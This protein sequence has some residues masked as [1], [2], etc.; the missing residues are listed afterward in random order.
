MWSLACMPSR[1]RRVKCREAQTW[2]KVWKLQWPTSSSSSRSQPRRASCT[3]LHESNQL[4]HAASKHLLY[5]SL[6]VTTSE[7]LTRDDR[8]TRH[9]ADKQPINQYKRLDNTYNIRCDK[10]D[11]TTLELAPDLGKRTS[12]LY[13]NL[14]HMHTHTVYH[15]FISLSTKTNT[16]H[17]S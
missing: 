2:S 17:T 7:Y 12:L 4:Y 15:C 9:L 13:D 14:L 5:A 3:L 8:L 16:Q 10:L 11:W 1:V 6:D